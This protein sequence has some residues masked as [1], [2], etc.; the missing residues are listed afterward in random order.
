MNGEDRYRFLEL[1][2]DLN[3]CIVNFK[4][5]IS[6]MVKMQNAFEIS[7]EILKEEGN[8]FLQAI[9]SCLKD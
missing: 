4:D 5:H 1:I 2:G 6:N 8:I 7:F 9:E 3:I